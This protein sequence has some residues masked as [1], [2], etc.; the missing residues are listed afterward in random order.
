[1]LHSSGL[2]QG[3]MDL[4]LTASASICVCSKERRGGRTP[5]AAV[6]HDVMRCDTRSIDPSVCWNMPVSFSVW[7]MDRVPAGL[8][9]RRGRAAL[10]K[11]VR[12]TP[13]GFKHKVESLLWNQINHK[14]TPNHENL[15][16]MKKKGFCL[17]K[18]ISILSIFDF[19]M[20]FCLKFLGVKTQVL[21]SRVCFSWMESH[22]FPQI[23]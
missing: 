2:K 11:V 5:G 6:S 4:I 18:F 10:L 15:F 1:M 12:R 9:C 19:S 7:I 21:L 13:K 16:Q 3:K 20:T 8:G 14:P 23:P 22:F 17:G